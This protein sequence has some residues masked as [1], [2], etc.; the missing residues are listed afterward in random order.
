MVCLSLLPLL[1]YRYTR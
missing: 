1:S